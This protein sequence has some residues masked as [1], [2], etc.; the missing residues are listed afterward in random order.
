MKRLYYIPL[1]LFLILSF[2]SCAIAPDEPEGNVPVEEISEEP[3]ADQIDVEEPPEEIDEEPPEEI[4][5]EPP[6]DDIVEDQPEDPQQEIFLQLVAIEEDMAGIDLTNTVPVRGV[7]FTIEGV[8]IADVLM[9]SRSENFM[10][11]YNE[12]N[13]RVLIVSF[14]GDEITPGEGLIAEVLFDGDGS[15]RLSEV[16]IVE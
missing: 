16:V 6:A 3:P 11:N 10:A 15:A 12:E 1:L 7:Q 8:E 13:G 2:L 4:D 9:T 5:E 14:A